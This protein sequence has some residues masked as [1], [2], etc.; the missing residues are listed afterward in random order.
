MDKFSAVYVYEE[1]G[2]L[3][4][5]DLDYLRLCVESSYSPNPTEMRDLKGKSVN[6]LDDLVNRYAEV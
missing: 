1:I 6:L 4:G 2:K 5:C 3:T